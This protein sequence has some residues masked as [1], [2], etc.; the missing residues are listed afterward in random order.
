[1]DDP[2][3]NRGQIA[4]IGK[5]RKATSSVDRA[6]TSIWH[7]GVHFFGGTLTRPYAIALKAQLLIRSDSPCYSTGSAFS[8]AASTGFRHADADPFL[9]GIGSSMFRAL[10]RKNTFFML[11]SLLIP[12]TSLATEFVIS[13]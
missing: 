8:T 1:M 5:R 3:P 10:S 9:S 11:F 12:V 13:A 2:E 6:L 7:R 4:I